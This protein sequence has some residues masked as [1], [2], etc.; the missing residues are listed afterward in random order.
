VN[1]SAAGDE[2]TDSN[3]PRSAKATCPNCGRG[4]NCDGTA[5]CWCLK[6]ER[7]FDYEAFIMRTGQLSCVCPVCL[8]GET[9]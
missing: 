9:P 6:V 1:Q 3:P 5:D 4:F 7:R 2:M 8:T